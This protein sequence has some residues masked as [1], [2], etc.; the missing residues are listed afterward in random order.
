MNEE[1]REEH[2]EEEDPMEDPSV[3]YEPEEKRYR[4]GG[5]RGRP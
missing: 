3:E 5:P 4:G 2:I 1:P